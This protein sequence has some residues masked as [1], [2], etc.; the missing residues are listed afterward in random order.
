[1]RERLLDC[2][3]AHRVWMEERVHGALCCW[4]PG[5]KV[6]YADTDRRSASLSMSRTYFRLLSVSIMQVDP[7]F[8]DLS[9]VFFYVI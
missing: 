3:A 1:M 5:S 6:S 9:Y 2:K 4:V 8:G 7:R